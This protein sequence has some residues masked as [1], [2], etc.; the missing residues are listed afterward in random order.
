MGGGKG[1]GKK[2]CDEVIDEVVKSAKKG[3]VGGCKGED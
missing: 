2:P 3:E 1:K